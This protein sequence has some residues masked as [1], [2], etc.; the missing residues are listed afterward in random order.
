M[1]DP[2]ILSLD[3]GTTSTRAILFDAKGH[4]LAANATSMRMNTQA[5][6]R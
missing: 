6:T 5:V 1:A 4:A 2:L 3:Q